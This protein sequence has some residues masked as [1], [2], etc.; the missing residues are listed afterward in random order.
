MIIEKQTIVQDK[1]FLFLCTVKGVDEKGFE[2]MVK[3]YVQ[4]L[5]PDSGLSTFLFSNN[6]D[7]AL[8]VIVILNINEGTKT[9]EINL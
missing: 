8:G 1:V 9:E 5:Y 3:D 4:H 6:V 7:G 2:F